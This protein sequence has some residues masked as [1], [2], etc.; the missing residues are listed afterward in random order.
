MMISAVRANIK[1]MAKKSKFLINSVTL[2]HAGQDFIAVPKVLSS[3]Y[4]VELVPPSAMIVTRCT[5]QIQGLESQVSPA[6]VLISDHIPSTTI[7]GFYIIQNEVQSTNLPGPYFLPANFT[8]EN[9]GN[10][11][12]SQSVFLTNLSI[13]SKTAYCSIIW[14]GYINE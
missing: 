8:I 6:G 4:T 5:I 10:E 9:F 2:L 1:A 7:D 14:E 12:I 3:D 11:S 13:Q